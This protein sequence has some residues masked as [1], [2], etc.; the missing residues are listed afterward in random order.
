MNAQRRVPLPDVLHDIRQI[1]LEMPTP[2]QK[3][4]YHSDVVCALLDQLFDGRLERWVH[5]FQEREFD[6]SGGLLPAQAFDDSVKRLRP[7][8]IARTMRKKDDGGTSR[9]A[10][11]ELDCS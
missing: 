7:R 5:A 11:I 1:F 9:L 6:T 4:R 3:Q 10:H 8:R 2:G